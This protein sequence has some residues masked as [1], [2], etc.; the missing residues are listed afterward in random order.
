MI[1]RTVSGVMT[2]PCARHASFAIAQAVR[3]DE[4]AELAQ[5]VQ[6]A[7]EMDAAFGRAKI[8]IEDLAIMRRR[9]ASVWN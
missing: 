5:R 1:P 9:A 6:A 8:L 4:N 3:R 2:L 7:R